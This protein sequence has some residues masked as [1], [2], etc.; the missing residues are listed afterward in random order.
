M[1]E[2]KEIKPINIE[3]QVDEMT[4]QGQYVNM[5]VATHSS[6]E[7]LLDF[8]FIPPGQL[9][10][11]VRSRI[12][13]APEHA[14]RLLMLLNENLHNYERRFGEIKLPELAFGPPQAPPKVVQ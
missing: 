8:V 12:L 1:N 4:A 3:I 10:A 7:F 2:N 5:V 6:S 11:R 9:K 14:K 13:L